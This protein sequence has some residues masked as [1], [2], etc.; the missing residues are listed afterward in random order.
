MWPAVYQLILQGW[1]AEFL[2]GSKDL[3]A[4]SWGLGLGY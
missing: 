3:L 1:R 2:V 4:E